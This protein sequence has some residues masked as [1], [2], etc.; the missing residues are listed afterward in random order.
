M[1]MM[2]GPFAL[3]IYTQMVHTFSPRSDDIDGRKCS[4]CYC[5]ASSSTSGATGKGLST[6][7]KVAASTPSPDTTTA[8][9][10]RSTHLL[11]LW[12]MQ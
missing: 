2:Q 8:R 5:I 1:A 4:C 10:R 3:H 9:V 6:T 7:E 11:S 12:Y